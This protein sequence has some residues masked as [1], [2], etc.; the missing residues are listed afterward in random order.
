MPSCEDTIFIERPIEKVFDTP[1]T[2]KYWPR[3]HPQ[4]KEVRGDIDHPLQLHEKSRERVKFAGRTKW[5]EW[6]CVN[7]DRPHTLRI[8]G[9][10]SNIKSYIEYTF[11]EREEGTEFTRYLHYKFHPLLK[12]AEYLSKKALRKLQT[13]SMK[14]M[15]EFLLEE[16]PP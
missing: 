9:T 15:K 6:K 3:W 4:C 5:V 16:I 10:S 14:Y 11:I 13:I 2:T 12:L 8:D 7:R 1:T